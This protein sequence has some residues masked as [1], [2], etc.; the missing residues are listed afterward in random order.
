[1]RSRF[2]V[3]APAASL[4]S[5][6]RPSGLRLSARL[7]AV[8]LSARSGFAVA[9]QHVALLGHPLN[10]VLWLIKDLAAT[11]EK[12]QEGEL[13]SLGSFARPQSP[14]AGQTVTVR[15]DGLPGGS[16]RASV[17]FLPGP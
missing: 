9:C 8:G 13:I 14:Q 5:T 10:P 1:M 7:P 2:T 11:D 16:L 17:Q 6:L 4:L 15:Y 3:A 12:L